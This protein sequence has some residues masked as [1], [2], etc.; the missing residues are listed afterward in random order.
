MI[1][2]YSLEQIFVEQRGGQVELKLVFVALSGALK[3]ESLRFGGVDKEQALRRAAKSLALRPDIEDV[4]GARLRVEVQGKL[5]DDP[6]LLNVFLK[7]FGEA[8]DD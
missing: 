6:V 5:S 7:A 4:G 2:G 3:R 8:K 1:S